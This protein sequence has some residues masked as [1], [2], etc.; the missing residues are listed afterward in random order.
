[1]AAPDVTVSRTAFGFE[2]QGALKTSRNLGAISGRLPYIQERA[3]STLRRRLPVQVR[4]DIQQE[5]A[6]KAGRVNKDLRVSNFAGG[7]R[8]TGYWRGIGLG[9]YGARDLR[10]SRRGVSY[11]VF[12][13]RRSVRPHSFI[14]SLL[15]G[16]K[17]SSGNVHVVHREGPKRRMT[18]GR[19]VGKMR[20]PLVTDY[21]PTVAQMLG[22]GRR[23]YRLAEYARGILAREVDRLIDHAIAGRNAANEVLSKF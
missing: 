8:V 20:Q 9:N 4:R 5:Y 17:G 23:P 14:A 7:I 18:A 3:M 22:K 11:T 21:G 12:R 2:L 6:I 19:Y 10:K 1:M 15:R 13:G 16:K